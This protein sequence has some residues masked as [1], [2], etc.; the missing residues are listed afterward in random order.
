MP[1]IT[2]KQSLHLPCCRAGGART[3]QMEIILVSGAGVTIS[4]IVNTTTTTEMVT[5]IPAQDTGVGEHVCYSRKTRM[6][7]KHVYKGAF[8]AEGL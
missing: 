1:Q 3:M 7:P 5:W 2:G 4:S 8:L 6:G